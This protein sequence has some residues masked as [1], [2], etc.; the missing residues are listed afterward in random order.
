MKKNGTLE[1]TLSV[2][3]Y[4]LI[5]NGHLFNHNFSSGVISSRF[6]YLSISSSMVYEYFDDHKKIVFYYKTEEGSFECPVYLT[7]IKTNFSGYRWAFECPSCSR[8]AIKLYF[9]NSYYK[10]RKCQGLV[11]ITSQSGKTVRA[12]IR[13]NKIKEKIGNEEG[14]K[15]KYMRWKKYYD[16]LRRKEKY[17]RIWILPYAKLF[18]FR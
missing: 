9:G 8:A 12:I 3:I 5:K 1:K 15:P 7:T 18:N 13:A 2:D 14:S 17:D 16:L 11:H 6:K 4:W 10:C